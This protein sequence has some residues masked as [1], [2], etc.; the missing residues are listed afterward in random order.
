MTRTDIELMLAVR[1]G[2]KAAFEELLRRHHRPLVRYFYRLVWNADTAEDCAQEVFCRLYIARERYEPRARFETYLYRIATHHWIDLCRRRR[3][4]IRTVSMDAATP[5]GATLGETLPG[6][7]PTPDS[8]AKR[9]EDENRLRGAIDRLPAKH[10]AILTLS[11]SEGL[12]HQEIAA[13]LGIP[14]GTVKSRLHAALQKLRHLLEGA[15]P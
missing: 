12:S 4:A 10:R 5:D 15:A 14:V 3:H 7:E 13:V 9:R 1:G 2:E 6:A 11:E 8:H